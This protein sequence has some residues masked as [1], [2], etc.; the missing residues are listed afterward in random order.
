MLILFHKNNKVVDVIDVELGL[1]IN[2]SENNP[3]KALF[4]L[5]STFSSRIICWAHFSY[6]GSINLEKLKSFFLNTN[7]MVS[8]GSISYLSDSI[9]YVED[10]LF[11]NVNKKVKYP[12]WLMHSNCGAIYG[13]HLLTFKPYIDVN[14]DLVYNL[15]SIA[16]LGISNGLYCY[17]SSKIIEKNNL[18]ATFKIASKAKLFQFVK[19]HYKVRWLFLLFLNFIIHEKKIL[20]IPLLKSL[21]YKRKYY[22]N[23]IA[24]DNKID[25]IEIEKTISVIIPTLGRAPYLYNVLKDLALQTLKPTE[26][27]IIEQGDKTFFKTELDYLKIDNWPFKIVHK[28]ITKTGAC[29]ARNIGLNFVTSKYTFFADDDI[30]FNKN[31]L[32]EALSF[33]EVQGHDAITLSC[34]KESEIETQKVPVQWKSFGSGC[35]IVKS[36]VIKDLKFNMAFE[37]GFGEDAD[38]GMQLRNKGVDV[39]YLPFVKLKHLK[40]PIGGFRT[41]HTHAWEIE[42]VLPKP[43][44]TI[45]LYNL[46][47]KTKE[48]VNSY[49]LT[50]FLKLYKRQSIKQPFKYY[51]MFKERWAKSQTWANK[52]ENKAI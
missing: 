44:P 15:N 3:T 24:S 13:K 1:K 33:M 51:N 5:S 38:Y 31:M 29:N 6:K 47:Y 39:I 28:L 46:K 25:T 34:L 20:I 19:E 48:Q 37:H 18:D 43:S 2:N 41:K 23:L 35:S 8:T 45:M 16:K 12:T 21:K 30:R 32:S 52:L 49:K 10:S 9:G 14:Q 50:L 4:N 17:A 26:V 42:K 7:T 22:K 40:A 27:I 11:I 36:N